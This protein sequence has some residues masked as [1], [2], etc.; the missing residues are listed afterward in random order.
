[1][2]DDSAVGLHL[3]AVVIAVEFGGHSARIL[4]ANDPPVVAI[5]GRASISKK[6]QLLSKI[7]IK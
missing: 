3:N 1:M 5:E 7:P 2:L 6:V 4:L